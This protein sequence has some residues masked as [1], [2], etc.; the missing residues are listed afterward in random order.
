MCIRDSSLNVPDITDTIAISSSGVGVPNEA[1]LN[2]DPSIGLTPLVTTMNPQESSVNENLINSSTFTQSI[3]NATDSLQE[4][5]ISCQDATEL[6][7]KS[8]Y[9]NRFSSRLQGVFKW[10]ETVGG[11]TYVV[12]DKSVVED[13]NGEVQLPLSD[14]T[15]VAEKRNA[16][17]KKTSATSLS[18]NPLDVDGES[19]NAISNLPEKVNCMM[20]E[21]VKEDGSAGSVYLSLHDLTLAKLKK[22]DTC[23]MPLG[24][25]EHYNKGIEP[26]NI[27]LHADTYNAT[28]KAYLN[29]TIMGTQG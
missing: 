27:K 16:V 4:N 6:I 12:E 10:S 29:L 15:K 24:G 19:T 22:G 18:S 17:I 7:W 11:N 14:L 28:N 3:E 25:D 23:L 1:V 2:I 5:S 20:V 26:S 8:K 9:T 13:L 21:Y